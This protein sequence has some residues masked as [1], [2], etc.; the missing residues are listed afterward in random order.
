ME[1]EIRAWDPGTLFLPRETYQGSF[2]G[3]EDARDTQQLPQ[4]K[5]S[6]LRPLPLQAMPLTAPLSFAFHTKQCCAAL[7]L[8]SAVLPTY[9]LRVLPLGFLSWRRLCSGQQ[10]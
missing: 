6:G 8:P 5:A 10:A 9:L 2:S 3:L 1:F 7:F 4:V